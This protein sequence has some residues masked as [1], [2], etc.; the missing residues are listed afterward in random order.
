[1]YDMGGNVM[2]WTKDN[3]GWA[4]RG[5]SWS[6]SLQT[7]LISLWTWRKYGPDH[8]TADGGFRVVLVD[9]T[10]AAP[11]APK[12]DGS[13]S[14][15]KFHL[16]TNQAAATPPTPA[17]DLTADQARAVVVITGDNSQGVGFLVK[18]MDGP[19]LVT[20]IHV[21]ANNPNLKITTNTGE[22]IAPLAL[23]CAADRDVAMIVIKNNH[24][25]ALDPAD[26][27][28]HTV[29]PGDDV[30]V[31]GVNAAG[32]VADQGAKI[33]GV[34][35]ERIELDNALAPSNSGGPVFHVKSGK[36]LGVATTATTVDISKS[37]PALTRSSSGF[38]WRLD[39]ISGWEPYDWSRF[40]TE[41]AFLEAFHRRS[42]CLDSYLNTTDKSPSGASQGGTIDSG[43][44]DPLM[45]QSDD[46]I[47]AAQD[48]FYK[49]M[50]ASGDAT[51]R[52]S[53]Y[54]QLLFDLMD[55]ANTDMDQIQSTTNFY[56]YDQKE[57]QREIDYRKV[58]KAELDAIGNDPARLSRLPRTNSSSA[59][60]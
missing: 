19:A 11:P 5:A 36:V 21:L 24:Y 25:S 35:A 30:I 14:F 40:N 15:G 42:R 1:L 44:L 6:R 22:L 26:D 52:Q 54:H 13:A 38:G 7:D 58:L 49:L 45:Y 29:Q 8:R 31:P 59:A 46:K 50:A 53:G 56:A 34:G 10:Q 37:S 57:A 4:R 27:I 39:T 41:T 48:N 3:E 9:L 18:T 47:Q 23:K 33:L 12:P 51:E 2:Q 17:L 16:P 60:K 43:P 28:S 20:T 55:I 32:V